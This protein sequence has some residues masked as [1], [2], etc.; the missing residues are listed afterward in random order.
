MALGQYLALLIAL[1]EVGELLKRIE[2]ARKDIVGMT[3]E[4]RIEQTGKY[5]DSSASFQG[6]LTWR[7]GAS[8]VEEKD[9]KTLVKDGEGTILLPKK[10]KA[11]V[12]DLKKYFVAWTLLDLDPEQWEIA[13]AAKPDQTK[14]P[15]ELTT[16]DGEKPKTP[17]VKLPGG[18]PKPNAMGDVEAEEGKYIVLE[19]KSKSEAIREIVTSVKLFLHKD[20]LRAEKIIV[21]DAMNYSVYRLSDWKVLEKVDEKAFVLDLEGVKIERK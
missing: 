15:D 12:Y 20:T 16:K 14:L 3:A 21:D 17:D 18:K 11:Q 5:E 9:R 10:K 7:P 1:D 4:V 19:L 8:I 6:K 2:E 13:I